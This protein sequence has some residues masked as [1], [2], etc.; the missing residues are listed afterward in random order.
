MMKKTFLLTCL[1]LLAGLAAQA[2]AYALIDMEY[3]L[4]HVPAYERANQQIEQSSKQWQAEVDKLSTEAK[5]LY[6][7]YQKASGLTAAQRTQ[8]ENAIVDKE[9]EAADLR[10]KYF[11]PEGELYKLRTKLM[12]P[13]EE[14]I[15][16]SV[17]TIAT[18]DGYDLV[19]DRAS[20]SS[21]I[22]AS[23]SID[24]SDAVLDL[25]GQ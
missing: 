11:G 16:E 22:F 20:A 25:L 18:E 14:A 24:I 10:R 13:I 23:P 21:V 4:K 7:S 12:A 19:I 17:K 3:I 6:E 2:Q 8:R 1:L 9:K 15:Y 5:N